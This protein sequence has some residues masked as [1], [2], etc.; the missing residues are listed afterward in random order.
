MR[1]QQGKWKRYRLERINFILRV[2][3]YLLER[4]MIIVESFPFAYCY[5]VYIDSVG[6]GWIWGFHG[7]FW[8]QMHFR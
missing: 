6:K 5:G 3:E 8:H 7:V 2:E 1:N 4:D